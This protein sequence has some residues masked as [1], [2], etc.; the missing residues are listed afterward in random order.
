LSRAP[1]GVPLGA[2]RRFEAR[3]L[4]LLSLAAFGCGA[5]ERATPVRAASQAPI[6]GIEEPS[7]VARHGERLFIVGDEEPG[8]YYTYPVDGTETG[9]IPLRPD[10]L[11]RHEI[12]AGPYAL[13][14]E[15]IDILADG[16]TA[17]VSERLG[18]ILDEKGFVSTYR[19][20]LSEFGG[21]GL[22]GLAVLELPGGSSRVAVLWEGGYPDDERLPEGVKDVVS[23]RS[24]RPHVVIHD[25]PSGAGQ[26]DIRKKNVW[27]EF[28]L[29]VPLPVG[30]EPEAQRFRAPDLVWH[31]WRIGDQETQ[32]LI[33]L[34]SSGYSVKP[35]EGS[36]EE[37]RK[38]R[39]SGKPRK[40]CY[41]VL[42]R[43]T[44]HGK[45]WGDPYDLEL[46]LPEVTSE[47]N[48]EGM[49][50]FEPGKSLVFVY[51]EKLAERIVDPQ[52]AFVLP[53]PEGW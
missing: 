28:E 51:D 8:T 3:S 32:G 33:V 2:P 39:D 20:S 37:C 4:L 48:W 52:E 10:R 6:L 23:K 16:R 18:A 44:L 26:I 41:K 35:E 25:V 47:A 1:G 36:V 7:G 27:T 40:F 17:I 34:L 31:E 38:I 53:L 15:A 29:E 22:E 14:L 21:R 12:A 13:D 5:G 49:G 43:Y 45:P 9:R 46:A 42:Q 24:I 19:G 50:W 11:E 30:R